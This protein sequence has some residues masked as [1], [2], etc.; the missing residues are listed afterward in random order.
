MTTN[1]ESLT[2]YL[3]KLTH[4]QQGITN[5]LTGAYSSIKKTGN[6]KKS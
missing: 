2:F 4:L 1:S 5:N 6:F 3:K